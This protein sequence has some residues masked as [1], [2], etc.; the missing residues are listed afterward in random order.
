[1]ANLT[2]L[3]VKSKFLGNIINN[4]PYNM[5]QKSPVASIGNK[6]KNMTSK[7]ISACSYIIHIQPGTQ[8]WDKR[9]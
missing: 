8:L 6:K 2:I 5:T 3:S 9:K 1:M 7:S 4:S